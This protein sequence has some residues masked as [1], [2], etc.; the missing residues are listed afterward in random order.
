MFGVWLRTS[1]SLPQTTVQKSLKSAD[2]GQTQNSVLLLIEA[3]V[4]V[5]IR[6]RDILKVSC[7][8]LDFL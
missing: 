5:R 6:S 2:N 7:F 4:G 8:T 1:W 3:V